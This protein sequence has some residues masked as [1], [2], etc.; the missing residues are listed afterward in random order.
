MPEKIYSLHPSLVFQIAS[1]FVLVYRSAVKPG[2]QNFRLIVE[3]WK[4][5]VTVANQLFVGFSQRL[6]GL[7]LQLPMME[8][9]T[10]DLCL[11][12]LA[13]V[14]SREGV[15]DR[16]FMLTQVQ[17]N[18]LGKHTQWK[19]CTSNLA[20]GAPTPKILPQD[21][22]SLCLRFLPQDFT[23]V[24]SNFFSLSRNG[25]KITLLSI[26]RLEWIDCQF[27]PDSAPIQLVPHSNFSF[28][29]PWIKCF[30]D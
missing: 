20:G 27:S 30:I 1:F 5:T 2:C 16:I 19:E 26:G 17:Q 21:F 11:Q 23:S 29:L 28:V 25:P 9:S 24:D 22:T 7:P 6:G 15:I 3:M 14:L 4:V 18:D 12:A 10:A 8:M 13:V